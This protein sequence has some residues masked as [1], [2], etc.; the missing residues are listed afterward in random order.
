MK[1]RPAASAPARS[2]AGLPSRPAPRALLFAAP[3]GTLE[4]DSRLL[5]EAGRA[6]QVQPLPPPEAIG[7]PIRI[8][9]DL[10]DWVV[11]RLPQR[12]RLPAWRERSEPVAADYAETVAALNG[13]TG[14]ALRVGPDGAVILSVALP[15]QGYRQ[16]VGGPHAG[17]RN[18]G[19]RGQCA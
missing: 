19:Y 5:M 12:L 18:G 11:G 8:S 14:R 6:V 16:V 9:N 13:E 15:V 2:F 1:S 10:Y 4:A 3:G 7:L 17:Q